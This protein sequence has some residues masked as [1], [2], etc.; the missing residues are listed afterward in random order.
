MRIRAKT[1]P[2]VAMVLALAPSGAMASGARNSA[3][4][5]LTAVPTDAPAQCHRANFSAPPVG[6][7]ETCT[8]VRPGA[9]LN[10]SLTY[11]TWNFMW[12]GSDGATYMGTAGHCIL[13]GTGVEERAWPRGG[14][15]VV[16]DGPGNRVGE[17]A[18]AILTADHRY[19]FGLVRIDQGVEVS[20]SLCHF[21]GPVGQDDASTNG[22]VVLHQ[23]GQ[24]LVVGATVPARTYLAT[25][26]TD[27]LETFANGVA[28]QGDSG[29][30]VIED[31]GRAL[32]W[33]VTL[34]VGLN[35][36]GD[37][38]T[39]GIMRVAPHVARASSSLGIR[40][41]LQNGATAAPTPGSPAALARTRVTTAASVTLGS[42]GRGGARRGQAPLPL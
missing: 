23:F 41:V 34:G 39:I 42:P 36:G 7:S 33:I 9:A 5:T 24:G 21:G 22:P 14:G 11:C 29:S 35:P 25:A 32:G 16:S 4:V 13:E 2:V 28:A 26:I 6:V 12:L 31:D 19:D 1:F 3:L 37:A 15:P 20:P 40:L 30:A 17:F 27:P 10:T 18:Y 8:G 38:G